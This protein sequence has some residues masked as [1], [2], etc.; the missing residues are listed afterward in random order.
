MVVP[1]REFLS[2]CSVGVA[3]AAGIHF[4]TRLV[5]LD[6]FFSFSSCNCAVRA[7]ARIARV[8]GDQGLLWLSHLQ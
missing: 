5:S 4:L 8:L 6:C 7:S 1:K 2:S 3:D